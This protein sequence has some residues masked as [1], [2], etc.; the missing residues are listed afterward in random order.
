M[1]SG[2][3][4]SSWSVTST[5]RRA[6]AFRESVSIGLKSSSMCRLLFCLVCPQVRNRQ[7]GARPV[8]PRFSAVPRGS[9]GRKPERKNLW[10]AK[11]GAAGLGS[12]CVEDNRKRG[13]D[14]GRRHTAVRRQ[15]AGAKAAEGNN[16]TVRA[17]KSR[18]KA[19]SARLLR[20]HVP[21]AGRQREAIVAGEFLSDRAQLQPVVRD[22]HGLHDGGVYARPD[23]M[24][25]L[26]AVVVD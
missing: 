14:D 15:G 25:V 22:M 18:G 2:N 13:A 21:H 23:N 7:T 3:R 6:R 4:L 12:C 16:K 17:T 26:A 11:E 10:I 24:V 20:L 19:R 9:A 1:N 8:H 5:M